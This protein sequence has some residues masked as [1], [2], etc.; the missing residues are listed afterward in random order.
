M[1]SHNGEYYHVV[2]EDGDS[3]EYDDGEMAQILLSPDLAKVTIGSR[4]AMYRSGDDQYHEAI[5]TRERINEK[6]F[7]LLYGNGEREWVDLRQHVCILLEVGPHHQSHRRQKRDERPV[8]E[9]ITL[10]ESD[11]DSR[12]RGST[13]KQDNSDGEPTNQNCADARESHLPPTE[14]EDE[15]KTVSETDGRPEIPRGL[16]YTKGLEY[17]INKEGVDAQTSPP[18]SNDELPSGDLAKIKVGSR[19]AV[20]RPDDDQYY[21]AFVTRERKDKR[22]FYLEYTNGDF[23]WLDLRHHMVILLEERARRRRRTYE[24]T[25]RRHSEADTD[26]SKVK[27]GKHRKRRHTKN[28]EDWKSDLDNEENDN[29]NKNEVNAAHAQGKNINCDEPQQLPA[30][31]KPRYE[32]GTKVKKVSTIGCVMGFVAS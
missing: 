25:S 8:D 3:E 29:Q 31:Y 30:S 15:G 16:A 21:E 14:S 13:L 18:P 32:I 28:G 24:W 23:E 6:P 10:P 5:V 12:R 20:Y 4:V 27:V 1:T 2:Y 17:E 11:S 26:E 9:S 19:V 7:Y 22:P